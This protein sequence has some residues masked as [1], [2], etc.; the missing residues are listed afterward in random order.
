MGSD[1]VNPYTKTNTSKTITTLEQFKQLIPDYG[2]YSFKDLMKSKYFTGKGAYFLSPKV[3]KQ[4]QNAMLGLEKQSGLSVASLAG[5]PMGQGLGGAG[6]AQP[7]VD[8]IISALSGAGDG[9]AAVPWANTE[10]GVKY[11]AEQQMAMLREEQRLIA[12][13]EAAQRVEE[14]KAR[15]QQIFSEMLGKDPVRAVLFGLGLSGAIP[16]ATM[17]ETASL[18]PLEG[19]QAY[20]RN[21]ENALQQAFGRGQVQGTGQISIG[22][23]G[24]KGL[25]TAIKSQNLFTTGAGMQGG[26][27]TDLQTLLSSA[28]GVGQTTGAQ[29][30]AGGQ[31][32]GLSPEELIRQIQDVTPRGVL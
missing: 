30:G 25:P 13:R 23:E 10:A 21:T 16:G 8:D 17:E 9:G 18:P 4:I 15:R 22:N 32:T 27:S 2:N 28:F 5:I 1:N 11:A 6:G 26:A 19:I 14:L 12:E 7:S 3:Y 24:V 20:Q 29:Y 31:Q